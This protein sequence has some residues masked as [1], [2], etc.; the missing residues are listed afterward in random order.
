[1]VETPAAA[2]GGNGGL[3]CEVS[4]SQRAARLLLY[5]KASFI[6]YSPS[7]GIFP[8]QALLE[9]SR[10]L[11]L[12]LRLMVVRFSNSNLG[13]WTKERGTRRALFVCR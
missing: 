12:S 4:L 9:D 2:N 7:G 10:W 1:M 13:I 6:D 5:L 11:G 3:A 8:C